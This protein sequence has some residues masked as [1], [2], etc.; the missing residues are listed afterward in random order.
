MRKGPVKLV[1]QMPAVHAVY[2]GLDP[3]NCSLDLMTGILS[4]EADGSGFGRRY[5][6]DGIE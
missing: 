4:C 5:G 3:L 2:L 6:E 1:V